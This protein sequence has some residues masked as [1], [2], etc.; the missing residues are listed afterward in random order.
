MRVAGACPDAVRPVS[1][2]EVAE[3]ELVGLAPLVTCEQ[4]R[5]DTRLGERSRNLTRALPGVNQ[6]EPVLWPHEPRKPSLKL[7]PPV[8]RILDEACHQIT[9]G[10]L[11]DGL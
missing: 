6:A 4:S 8:E 5:T 1:R 3:E 10:V 9:D 2:E 7:E 11:V